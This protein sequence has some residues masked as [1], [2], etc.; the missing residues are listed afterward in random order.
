MN[1]NTKTCVTDT[2]KCHRNLL[3]AESD[4]LL[5][6]FSLRSKFPHSL[7]KWHILNKIQAKLNDSILKLTKKQS[8]FDVFLLFSVSLYM[9]VENCFIFFS[10]RDQI[11]TF[12]NF[13]SL[14]DGLSKLWQMSENTETCITDAHKRH[15]ACILHLFICGKWQT[16][17]IFF[18]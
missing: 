10:I 9:D 1:E 7:R 11:I 6:L 3:N 5:S 13:Y 18:L 12:Y 15:L 2:Q 16:F 8:F 4:N 17:I 14:T